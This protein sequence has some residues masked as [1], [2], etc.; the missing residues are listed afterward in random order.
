MPTEL[1]A[2]SRIDMRLER[3]AVGHLRRSTFTCPCGWSTTSENVDPVRVRDHRRVCEQAAYPPP[4]V[5]VR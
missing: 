3:D 5:G 4:I 1:T 2:S